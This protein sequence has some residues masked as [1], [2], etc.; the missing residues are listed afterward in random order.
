MQDEHSLIKY[1]VE[2]LEDCVKSIGEAME[3]FNAFM[4]SAKVWAKVFLTL[5]ILVIGVVQPLITALLISRL[6]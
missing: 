4:L 2:V 5:A 1:R 6:S 3:T